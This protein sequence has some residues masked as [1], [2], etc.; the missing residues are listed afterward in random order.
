MSGPRELERCIVLENSRISNIPMRIQ[1]S[2]IGRNAVV[3][4][5]P[6]KPKAI[7]MNLG[8]HSHVGLR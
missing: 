3:E 4:E 6:L 5:S 7:K 2:L 1:D 8:D